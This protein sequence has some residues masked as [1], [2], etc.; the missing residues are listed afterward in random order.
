MTPPSS[1]VVAGIALAVV[2]AVAWAAHYLFVRV[3][4]DAGNVTNAV[5]V[6]MLCNLVLFV[7]VTVVRHYPEFGLGPRSTLLFVAAGLG[8]GLFGRLFQFES[9]DRIGASRTSPI[10]ASAGLVSTLL[11]VT[12]LH[13]SLT[14]PHLAGILLIVGG[15]VVTSWETASDPGDDESLRMVAPSLVLPFLAAFFYGVEP[16]L[17]KI[18]LAMG[19]PYLVGMTVMILSAFVGFAGYRVVLGTVSMRT[20]VSDPALRWYL[21]AGAISALA[22]VTYF[23]ALDVAPVVVVIPIFD[24]VPLLVVVFSAAF[25]PRHL[26]RVT[27]RVGVAAIVVVSGAVLVTLSA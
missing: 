22:F 2:G 15:V 21:G 20:I 23:A 16:V 6:A 8:S 19:V 3:G 17:V 24:A 12:V 1:P 27:W 13:E 26:E 14:L 4:I 18:G 25:M 11:A 7:P 5:W 10:V 9:T